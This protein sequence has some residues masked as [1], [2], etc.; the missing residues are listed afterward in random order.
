MAISKL[1][2][3]II[4]VSNIYLRGRGTYRHNNMEE[5]CGYD[6]F[7]CGGISELT[8]IV[9]GGQQAELV[10]DM[11][12]SLLTKANC[13]HFP[14]VLVKLSLVELPRSNK[15]AL[16]EHLMETLHPLVSFMMF[17]PDTIGDKVTAYVA[18]D[19][20]GTPVAYL[21][22]GYT[23]HEHTYDSRFCDGIALADESIQEAEQILF[24]TME[25]IKKDYASENI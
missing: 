9:E 25:T 4:N 14:K 23:Q 1:I 17:A 22:F 19:D 8:S 18:E 6:A 20:L 2:Q 13:V 21:E 24:L 11:P 16:T 5:P 7:M 12:P 15:R 3:N 10:I